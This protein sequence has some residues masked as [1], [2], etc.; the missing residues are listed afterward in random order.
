LKVWSSPVVSSPSSSSTS[1][2]PLKIP[3]LSPST[4]LLQNFNASE[5]IRDYRKNNRASRKCISG[6]ARCAL[7][8]RRRSPAKADDRWRSAFPGR[9]RTGSSIYYILKVHYGVTRK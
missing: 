1:K 3:V 6:N 4:F 9:D 8:R 5:W 2:P 7:Q